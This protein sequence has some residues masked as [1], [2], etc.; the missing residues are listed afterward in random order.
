MEDDYKF[1]LSVKYG[2]TVDVNE[3]FSLRVRNG[4]LTI[5]LLVFIFLLSNF[6]FMNLLIFLLM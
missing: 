6:S 3:Q 4:V 5:I 1:L 2:D